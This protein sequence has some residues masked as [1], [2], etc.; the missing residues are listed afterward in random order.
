M[1]HRT[2]SRCLQLFRGYGYCTEYDISRQFVDSRV[3]S[4]FG[5]ASEIMKVII[6]KEMGL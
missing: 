6:A 5:G 3:Q 1:N 4:I 2:A